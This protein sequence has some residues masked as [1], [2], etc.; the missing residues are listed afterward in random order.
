MFTETPMT[1][2]D[3]FLPLSISLLL[4]LVLFVF[5][6]ALG[7]ILRLYMKRKVRD[8]ANEPSPVYY[9]DIEAFQVTR[10]RKSNETGN[11]TFTKEFVTADNPA[12]S[13]T[14]QLSNNPTHTTDFKLDHNSAYTCTLDEIELHSNSAYIVKTQVT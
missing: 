6:F 14:L 1:N 12:Y 13:T 9:E 8:R 4:V 3:T 7:G 2:P 10:Y 11:H 5:S